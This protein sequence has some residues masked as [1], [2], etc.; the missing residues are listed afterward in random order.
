[1]AAARDPTLRASPL[2]LLREPLFWAAAAA[3]VGTTV[4]LVGTF[5][6][7]A[8]VVSYTPSLSTVLSRR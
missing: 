2:T 1:M 7:A 6:Q 5:A 8:V 4:G 3:F